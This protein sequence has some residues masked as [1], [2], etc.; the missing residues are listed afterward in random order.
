MSFSCKA[1]KTSMTLCLTREHFFVNHSGFENCESVFEKFFM[2]VFTLIDHIKHYITTLR[3]CDNLTVTDT[4]RRHLHPMTPRDT[5]NINDDPD[6]THDTIK[7]SNLLHKRNNQ[8]MAENHQNNL[9]VRVCSPHKSCIHSPF[10]FYEY[11]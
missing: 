4:S 1:S 10:I 3:N 9:V 7:Y 8:L 11:G 2:N 5:I 6:H